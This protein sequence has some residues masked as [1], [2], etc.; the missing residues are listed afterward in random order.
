[1][2]E[3][4]K[5]IERKMK[6]FIILFCSLLLIGCSTH[7]I[8]KDML[9]EQLGNKDALRIRPTGVAPILP[10]INPLYN[11]NQTTEIYCINS[12]GEKVFL[13]VGHNSLLIINDKQGE[14][15]KFYL[16][17][18][19]IEKDKIKGLRSRILGIVNEVDISNIEAIEVYS[20]FA[21]EAK[22]P[23]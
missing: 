3:S 23:Q 18:V 14:T 20:E 7:Y 13:K 17:S 8:T 16:D 19:Y 22:A 5:D 9:M 21:S 1:M 12:K 10:F 11:G 2:K 4:H 6:K 15:Y